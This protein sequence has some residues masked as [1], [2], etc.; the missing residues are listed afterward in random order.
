MF[1]SMGSPFA[2]AVLTLSTVISIEPARVYLSRNMGV[3]RGHRSRYL[4]GSALRVREAIRCT[5]A[6]PTLFTPLEIEG[7]TYCDGA[8]FA[9]NVS[10]RETETKNNSQRSYE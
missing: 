7:A 2:P 4:G 1:E 10:K 5:T 3:A 9:N 6:A 8:F